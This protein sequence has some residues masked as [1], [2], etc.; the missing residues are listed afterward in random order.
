M[1]YKSA[2]LDNATIK[3]LPAAGERGIRK[4]IDIANVTYKN[5]ELLEE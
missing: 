1:K 2:D 4:L 3:M 5:G